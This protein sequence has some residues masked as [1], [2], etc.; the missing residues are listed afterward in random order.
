MVYCE[1]CNAPLLS[2]T[3]VC[4]NC[5]R[6]QPPFPPQLPGGGGRSYRGW[7]YIL[8]GIGL[9]LLIIGIAMYIQGP[10]SNIAAFTYGSP[11][12]YIVNNQPAYYSLAGGPLYPG[13]GYAIFFGGFAA[14][15]FFWAFV[16]WNRGSKIDQANEPLLRA[17]E[18]LNNGNGY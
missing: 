16:S 9:G 15:L 12:S 3:Q 11:D 17:L 8:G 4:P 13:V 6:E 5:Q 14:V 10:I 7:A 18:R 2:I 1:Y